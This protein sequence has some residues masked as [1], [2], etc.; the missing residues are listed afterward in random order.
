M[1]DGEAALSLS[2]SLCLYLLIHLSENLLL[3]APC[4]QARTPRPGIIV[5]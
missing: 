4:L 3:A 5:R 2:L 1:I